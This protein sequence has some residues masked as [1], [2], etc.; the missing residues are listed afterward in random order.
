MINDSDDRYIM[1]SDGN[2]TSIGTY[3]IGGEPP[4]PTTVSTEIN[5]KWLKDD[6][7]GKFYPIT[8]RAFILGGI[9]RG[10]S[11][12]ITNFTNYISDNYEGIFNLIVIGDHIKYFNVKLKRK[13]GT[14]Q[15]GDNILSNALPVNY[16]PQKHLVF[17]SS[18]S[19]DTTSFFTLYLSSVDGRLHCFIDPRYQISIDPNLELS[20]ILTAKEIT[21]IAAF[22]E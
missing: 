2:V 4:S 19:P 1:D 22:I 13:N 12:L 15:A 5:L 8:S 21:G 3:A 10:S 17:R 16:Y 9:G 20:A 14:L 18:I 11:K 6:I 7:S